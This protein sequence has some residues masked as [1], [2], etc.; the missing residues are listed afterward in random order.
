MVLALIFSSVS[1]EV[2]K[3]LVSK[4]TLSVGPSVCPLFCYLGSPASLLGL[5]QF[6][7][8]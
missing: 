3:R 7:H 4:G 2:V 6:L 8:L 5:S 1:I